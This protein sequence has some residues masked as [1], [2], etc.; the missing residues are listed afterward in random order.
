MPERKNEAKWVESR[1]RW[2]INV[3]QDGERRT[4]TCSIQGTKGKVKAEKDADRWLTER[5]KD[6]NIRFGKL[7]TD[8]LAEID[9]LAKSENYRKHEQMGRLWLLPALQ[10]K[11][12]VAITPQ[13]W[14]DCIN[15]AYKKGLSKKTCKNIRASITA[16]YRYAKKRR[17]P[18]G[19]PEDLTIP[20]DA[21]VGKRN[22]LQ[23]N[24]IKTLFSID[25]TVK[26][27]K[28]EKCFFIYAW[29]FLLLTGLRRGELCGIR[30][31][32]I[33]NGILHIQRSINDNNEETAGKTENAQ[34]YI[35]ISQHA[36]AV[37]TDQA[38]MLKKE[39]VISSWI[40]PDE[41]GGCLDPKHLYQI[42]QTYRSQNGIKCSLHEM[43]HTLISIA[44]S[45]VPEEL[46]K[47]AVGHS[48]NMDTFGVY[49][50][51]VEGDMNRV[52]DILDGL[53]D[54]ILK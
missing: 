35:A 40:F 28:Q 34:R 18:M 11:K 6:E 53:F 23:P 41:R 5:T 16:L 43:R 39:G 19:K 25:Y 10:H 46:L 8:F 13:N 1:Q 26:Y 49:G 38:E 9:I 37:L 30:K 24:D 52:A 21:P 48:Q 42:W 4:F 22:I 36:E 27:G 47:R 20:K 15:A 44:K 12:A 14:Q 29:R 51:D 31:E 54:A 33:N 2:Q 17:V 50:H 7:W 32:D 3:Q 45:D